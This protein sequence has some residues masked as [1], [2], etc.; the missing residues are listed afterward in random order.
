M[1]VAGS[2]RARRGAIALLLALSL[3]IGFFATRWLVLRGGGDAVATLKAK[4]GDADRDFRQTVGSWK[5]VELHA[6]LFV[7]DGVG[8]GRAPSATLTLADRGELSLEARTIIRFLDR[9]TSAHT[10][11]LDLQMGEA[12]LQVGG[13]P[14]SLDT[15]IGAAVLRPGSRISLRRSDTKTRYEVLVGMA[16]F[17]TKDGQATDV[18][19]GEG[20]EIGIGTAKLERYDVKPAASPSPAASAPQA[21]EAPVT[22]TTGDISALVVGSGASVRA[23]GETKFARLPAGEGRVRAGTTLRL[24]SGTTADVAR[25]GQRV[26]LRGAGD[27]VVAEPGKPFI[28]TQGGG[29]ALTGAGSEVEIAGPGGAPLDRR[30]GPGGGPGPKETSPPER[31]AGAPTR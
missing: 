28:I 11:H 10:Q 3:A 16:R 5:P 31:D 12:V 23:P 18:A 29:V 26:T 9:P 7:G 19:A 1:P 6:Q 24:S 2:A 21:R 14:L 15:E 4:V 25:G 13:E 17:E 30:R 22:P 8:P 20:V 27:F